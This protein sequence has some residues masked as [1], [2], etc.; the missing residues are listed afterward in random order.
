MA[1]TTKGDLKKA[2][3][4][5]E[6][7]EMEQKKKLLIQF[8]E[9]RES[10]KPVNVIKNTFH[11][12]TSG[13][14]LGNKVFN[15]TLGIGAGLLTKKIMGVPGR[16]IFNRVIAPLLELGVAGMIAKN[17]QQIKA[18][19]VSLV[20]KFLSKHSNGSTNTKIISH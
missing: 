15:A 14:G 5:L 20:K 13:P 4:E 16:I 17:G 7:K 18:E 10:L 1:I 12:I 6:T 2:I 9:T 3:L 8:Q 19:A 11:E